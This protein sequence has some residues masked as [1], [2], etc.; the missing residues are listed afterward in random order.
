MLLF[1]VTV[2]AIVLDPIHD[3]GNGYGCQNCHMAHVTLGTTGY[4]N[5]CLDC[6]KPGVP[7]GGAKPYVALDAADPFNVYTAALPGTRFQHSHRWFG[8]ITVPAAGAQTPLLQSMTRLD[9]LGRTNEFLACVSCHNPHSNSSKPFLR[10]I[11]NSDQICLDCHRSRNTSSHLSGSHPVNV[12]YSSTTPLQPVPVN[13]NPANPTAAMK[14]INGK[15]LCTTCHG[16]HTT[17]SNSATFDGYSSY[18]SLKPSAGY[19]LRT[20]LRG[21]TANSVNICTNCHAGKMAHNSV[22]QNIQCGD[23][24]GAHVEYDP[25]AVSAQEKIPNVFL[26][27][28]Y[29]NISTP[30]GKID[31]RNNSNRRTFFQM[32]G[33]GRNYKRGDGSGVCQSCHVV[34][35]SGFNP[36]NGKQYPAQHD[37]LSG[38]AQICNVC[39]KH[40][41]P[42][43]SFS[44]DLSQS[45][46]LCHG[47]P[48]GTSSHISHAGSGNMG[49]ACDKCHPATPDNA[50]VNGSVSWS[51]ATADP[52]FGNSATYR[53]SASGSTGAPAPS[54]VY[55]TCN[56]YCHSNGNGIYLNSPTWNSA[57][58]LG[59][60]GCHSK[61]GD[62]APTWSAPHT[63]HVNSYGANPDFG[64]NAC[65]SGTALNNLAINGASGRN[66]HPDGVKDVQFSAF[67][68]GTWSGGQCSN[69]WCHSQG[70]SLTTP[71]HGPLAWNPP[72]VMNC[73]SCHSGG[74]TAGPTYANGS[75]KANSH[76]A[77]TAAMNCQTCHSSV[78]NAADDLINLT[79]H[80]NQLYDIVAGAGASFSVT[81]GTGTPTSPAQCT[82]ISC[83]GGN[84][85][86]WGV[87]INCQECHGGPVDL[88]NFNGSFWNDGSIGKIR[89]IGEW[90]TSGHGKPSGVY[91]SGNPAADFTGTNACEYCHDPGVAHKNGSNPFR[92]RNYSTTSWGRNAPCLICHATS[93]TGFTVNG[94]F[95]NRTLST[96][97]NS[98]HSGTKHGG[99][100]GTGGRFCWDCH[101][102]HG[103]SNIYMIHDAVAQ[104]SDAVTGAPLVTR[105]TV[106]TS[107]YDGTDFAKSTAPFDG[108]CNVCHTATN[109]YRA[110][111]GNNHYSST[112]C[113]ECHNHNAADTSSAFKPIYLCDSCHGYPPV[114]RGL[115]NGTIFRQ[116]NYSSAR[117]EKYSGGGGA[118]TIEKH[119]KSTA[120]PAEGWANCAICHSKGNLN[121]S[122]HTMIMPVLPSNVTIDVDPR[123]TYDNT[124]HLAPNR[125][126]G[127][128]LDNYNNQSGTCSNIK[129]HF[130]PAKKWSSEK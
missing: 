25:L 40:S 85:A 47:Y 10:M 69:T 84:T 103:D 102:P 37:D 129:C 104:K 110:T 114:R 11:N 100:N 70:T 1:P 101:D 118:H 26:I 31:N 111:A 27:K 7:T 81:A 67:A 76:A 16:V 123:Y 59:C 43:G 90:D 56:V 126:S 108:I 77:H 62:P 92:L 60:D 9:L 125:Y 107:A 22:G 32:T 21:S 122:T 80:V 44:V 58:P 115:A 8:S 124:R 105:P 41:N 5:I 12:H 20:D 71:L 33:A 53:A 97:I 50:H 73:S 4:N 128:L 45:C 82:N 78:I 99:A 95:R 130:K 66:Q 19:L 57:V 113:V 87:A 28:R 24:H 121:P 61:A 98:S 35:P 15:V 29:M 64:C 119:L 52:K 17:D 14:L 116:G 38:N 93:A 49:L 2:K 3:P 74:I 106:F 46:A 112:I 39:H 91:W 120:R 63:I 65:H 23:C 6:H 68:K 86:I 72:P 13:A 127:I 36:G 117:F 34:P 75:P 42:A 88:N 79:L 30:F 55:G 109:N 96:P 51:L 54:A 18:Y 83:H 94:V 89:V 48:P